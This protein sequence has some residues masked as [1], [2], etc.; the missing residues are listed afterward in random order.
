MHS[1]K[2][3]AN[4]LL[5]VKVDIEAKNRKKMFSRIATRNWDAVIVTHSGFERIPLARETQERFFEEQLH[6]LEMIK[7]QH[8]DS[9]NR[10]LVKEIE[11]AKKRLES[12]LQALAAEHKKDN[13]LT[14]EELGVDRLFVDEAHYFKNLF[15]V[16]KMTRIVGMHQSACEQALHIFHKVR[17]VQSLNGGGGVVFATGTPIA[18]S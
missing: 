4:F 8:A 14:F 16:T 18:N 1:L 12:R 11:R 9:S 2:T 15:Y 6:E 17:H 7:R 5:A 3:G 13:T 10:R